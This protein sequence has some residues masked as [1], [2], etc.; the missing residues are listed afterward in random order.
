MVGEFPCAL[1]LYIIFLNNT[2]L[3][4]KFLQLFLNFFIIVC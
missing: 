3:F 2:T 1:L 4:F